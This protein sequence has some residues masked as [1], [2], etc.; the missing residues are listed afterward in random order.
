MGEYKENAQS[1]E[2][3]IPWTEEEGIFC[4]A[5]RF[6]R[7]RK[8][9]GLPYRAK[10]IPKSIVRKESGLSVNE[11]E[12]V[13]DKLKNVGRVKSVLVKYNNQ[14]RIVQIFDKGKNMIPE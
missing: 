9:I 12:K 2:E 11:F 3:I 4:S 14:G 6:Q 1:R 7:F 5:S 10:F 13:W 8:K